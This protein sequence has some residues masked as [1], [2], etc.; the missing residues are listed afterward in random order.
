MG[1]A[2]T[3]QESKAF[4]QPVPRASCTADPRRVALAEIKHPDSHTDRNATVTATAATAATGM[5]LGDR[6]DRN[7]IRRRLERHPPAPAERNT[8]LTHTHTHT[9]TSSGG[10]R[11]SSSFRSSHVRE[12]GSA[13]ASETTSA[14]SRN[15]RHESNPTLPSRP[16]PERDPTPPVAAAV[17]HLGGSGGRETDN[18]RSTSLRPHTLVA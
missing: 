2:Q 7:D 6:S 16:P 5:P 18:A 4:Q 9:H 10:D 1:H 14:P 3:K 11:N 12:R 17:R 8:T 15:I 13:G